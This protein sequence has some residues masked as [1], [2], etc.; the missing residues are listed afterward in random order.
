MQLVDEDD[1]VLI[2]HQLLHDGLEPL[3]KLAAILGAGDDQRKI[4][5]QD[6]LVGEKA[7]HVALGDA[8]REPF[9][10]GG[11]ADARLSDQHGIVLGAP[12]QNLHHALELMISA[13]ERIEH[14]IH[15]R[16]R[17]V[18]AELRQQRTLLGAI[19]RSL[20]RL[21][22]RQLFP[23]RREP[24]SALMQDFRREALLF[25]Q[26]AQQQ[27]LRADV[28]V[29][30]P[31]GFFGAIGQHPLALVAER[32]VHRRRNLLPD[33]GV[34]FDLLA[35]RIHG[36]MRSQEPVSQRLI[37]PKQTQQQVLGLDVG[38]AELARLIPREEYYPACFF[39]VAFKHRPLRTES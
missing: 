38:A 12:A 22:T 37:F 14:A 33:R 2:L 10:D 8:L 32:Q 30:E 19:R 31:L 29:I 23:N 7:R 39:R 15:R 5:R 24:Q 11:L 3:F 9:D 28:L 27:M 20:L 13:N 1:G 35:D 25:A 34:P 36:R 18:A 26:Q 6:P 17:Q 4:E 21:R 16:L